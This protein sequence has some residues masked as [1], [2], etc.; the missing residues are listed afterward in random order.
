MK[1][2]N[3]KTMMLIGC[4]VLVA[5]IAAAAIMLLN[6]QPQKRDLDGIRKS[7]KLVVGMEGNGPTQGTPR[8][9]GCLI[10][11]RDGHRLDAVAAGLIDGVGTLSDA[12]QYLH[13]RA[14]SA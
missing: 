1:K 5:A 12:L 13:E 7:G 3:N 11:S 9:I 2:S 14:G 6:N 4:L 10:A 8:Q